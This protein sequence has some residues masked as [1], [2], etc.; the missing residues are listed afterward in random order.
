MIGFTVFT[1]YSSTLILI[2]IQVHFYQVN[3][4]LMH[5]PTVFAFDFANSNYSHFTNSVRSE[6]CCKQNA[7]KILGWGKSNFGFFH[8]F[9]SKFIHINFKH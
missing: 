2:Y 4:T 8:V 3:K 7:I 5:S 6:T 9:Q 1:S